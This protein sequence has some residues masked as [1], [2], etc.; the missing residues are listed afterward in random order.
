MCGRYSF[1]KTDRLDW[2]RF[3]VARV[4]N[5]EP[6]W[7]ISPGT[8]VLAVRDGPA[9]RETAMLHWG[10]IPGNATDPAI[11]HRLVN[12]RAE[13]A[14]VTPTFRQ[15]FRSRRCVLPADGF[16]EWEA[17]VGAKKKQPWRVEPADGGTLA[18]GGLWEAWRSREGEVRETVTILTVKANSALAEIHDR[19]PVL[20]TERDLSLWLSPS[21]SVHQARAICVP[22]PDASIMAWRISMA[23]NTPGNQ[24]IGVTDPATDEPIA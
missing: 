3:G 15:A 10:F 19:M 2:S 23:I 11:G 24:D 12:A 1:G 4:P 20:I 17:V 9:S 7:N 18:L 21:S 14:H 6:R 8:D 22:A 5:L 16:S 13:S